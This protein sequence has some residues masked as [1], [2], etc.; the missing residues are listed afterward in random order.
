MQIHE[1]TLTLSTM[2]IILLISVNLPL[3][4]MFNTSCSHM[5]KDV[6]LQLKLQS[7]T[8]WNCRWPTDDGAVLY[9][10]FLL[11]FSCRHINVCSIHVSLNDS[12]YVCDLHICLA[13]CCEFFHSDDFWCQ[14]WTGG[15]CLLRFSDKDDMFPFSVG[16]AAI[17]IVHLHFSSSS[18][19]LS[20]SVMLDRSDGC[21][22][23]LHTQAKYSWIVVY[24]LLSYLL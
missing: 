13:Q 1:F 9:F 14:A 8:S 22:Y 3:I 11:L 7:L 19:C 21:H 17:Q 18:S 16:E 5:S 10:F 2:E 24:W 23:A 15:V 20:S 12:L 6:D 4:S